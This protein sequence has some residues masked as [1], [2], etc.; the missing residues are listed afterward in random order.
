METIT[1]AIVIGGASG[2]AVSVII[3]VIIRLVWG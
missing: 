1:K 2:A 3:C